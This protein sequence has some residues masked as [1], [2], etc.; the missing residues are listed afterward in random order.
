MNF[1]DFGRFAARLL[2]PPRCRYCFE[3]VPIDGADVCERCES[4]LPEIR[5]SGVLRRG[6][7]RSERNLPHLDDVISS[8]IY[9]EPISKCVTRFKNMRMYYAADFLAEIIAGDIAD[10]GL[11]AQ[12]DVVACVPSGSRGR[13]HAAV[14]ARAVAK[15]L[16][17]EFDGEAL[18]RKKRVKVQHYL[19]GKSRADNL[20]GAY[21]ASPTAKEKTVL[22]VDDVITSG[23]TLNEAARA[24]K[25]VGAG[26][27]YAATL[28]ATALADKK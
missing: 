1:S 13:E 25:A 19:K 3:V 14:L 7:C 6:F 26:A 12:I 4:K 20:R 2:V 5:L 8:Y 16:G 22:V 27:V 15:R 23:A 21:V 10:F 28:A 24:L 18:L 17:K 11:A 9:T